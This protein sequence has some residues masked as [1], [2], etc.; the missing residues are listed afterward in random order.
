MTDEEF[1][2]KSYDSHK[3]QFDQFAPAGSREEHANAW[4]KMDSVDAWRHKRIYECLDPLL[5]SD[6][7]QSWL[8]VG[9]GRY[10]LDAQYLARKGEQVMATD[11]SNTLLEVAAEQ[12]LINSY[13]AENAEALSF[14]NQQF[15]YVLCKDAYHHFPRP[16]KALY[17]TLRVASR[18][19][20]LIEPS[21]H[22]VH[23]RFLDFL[24][25]Q[26]SKLRCKLAGRNYD[27]GKYETSGNYV[28]RASKYE[29]KKVA[30]GLNYPA[31][32]FKGI[33]DYYHPDMLGEAT[34]D[35]GPY[36]KRAKAVIGLLDLL[37][38]LRLRDY[39]LVVTVLIKHENCE[40]EIRRLKQAKF[41]VISLSRN[42]YLWPQ[43]QR[44]P[45][46]PG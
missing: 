2:S 4:L 40:E 11:I 26:V 44:Q 36:L 46:L 22:E 14:H 17:E 20:V 6:S 31:V 32:A 43:K 1:E 3:T 8:T 5:V 10:G 13:R 39:R 7:P 21:D 38:K 37:S 24:Q 28:Y 34:S 16:M 29:L 42:P 19:V 15:D 30:L 9:D 35:N 45:T 23:G 18:S 27:N 33:N 25:R 41:K 12:G